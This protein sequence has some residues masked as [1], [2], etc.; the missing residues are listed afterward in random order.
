M[1]KWIATISTDEGNVDLG[2]DERD[3]KFFVAAA[4]G[5]YVPIPP[6]ASEQELRDA[7][8]AKFQ[9][10]GLTWKA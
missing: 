1:I 8:T 3:G 4:N 2:V 10:E 9:H 7:I 5:E 6:Q